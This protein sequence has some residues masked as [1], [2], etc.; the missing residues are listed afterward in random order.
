MHTSIPKYKKAVC[1]S[2]F[3]VHVKIQDS[4]ILYI[5]VYCVMC[6][7]CVSVIC[8]QIHG[9]PNA[10]SMFIVHVRKYMKFN[11]HFEIVYFY[12]IVHS[13]VMYMSFLENKMIE[14]KFYIIKF[15]RSCSLKI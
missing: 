1:S 15:K 9:V 7:I 10:G 5:V 4:Y 11:C 12:C 3:I 14:E 13:L 6:S 2:Y 8:L